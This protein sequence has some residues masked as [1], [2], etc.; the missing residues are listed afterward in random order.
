MAT[1]AYRRRGPRRE[2]IFVSALSTEEKA[3][4]LGEWIIREDKFGCWRAYHE[5]GR[6]TP[7]K[8]GLT[9]AQEDAINNRCVCPSWPHCQ[10]HDVDQ[11]C[12]QAAMIRDTQAA[13]QEHYR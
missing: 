5:D 7:L 3:N 1:S 8:G 6:K 4:M 2:W 11:C 9:A 13:K 10:H 12:E